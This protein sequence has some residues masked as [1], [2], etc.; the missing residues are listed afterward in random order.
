MT[1]RATTIE[2]RRLLN[3]AF[4]GVLIARAV[5]GYQS[6]SGKG[7][8]FLYSYLI[9]PLVLHSETRARLPSTVVTR[10][11]NWSERNAE[12]TTHLSRRLADL[13][14]ATKEGLLLITTMG[15]AQIVDDARI[16]L[17]AADKV[18]VKFEKSTPSAE[19]SNCCKKAH[20]VGRWLA[21]SGT[22][23]TV[24]TALGVRL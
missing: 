17:V 7:F 1:L 14:L 12:L 13:A 6:E 23:P 11:I 21:S 24:F 5:A 22:A 9:L 4:S 8:P 15:L 3:P 16:E 20:F 2:E 19:V 10:L 18:F